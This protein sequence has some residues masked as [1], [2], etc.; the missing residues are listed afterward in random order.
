[1]ALTDSF[2]IRAK[3]IMGYARKEVDGLK[4]DVM[5]TEHVLLGIMR[6][7]TGVA[8]K[9]LKGIGLDW[10]KIRQEIIVRTVKSPFFALDGKSPF[11]EH[12]RA[13]L[14]HAIKAA[15]ASGGTLKTEH[16]LVGMLEVSECKAAEV[17]QGLGKNLADIRQ[18][19]LAM[20][21]AGGQAPS[22]PGAQMVSDFPAPAPAPAGPVTVGQRLTYTER[23]LKAL[24]YA[25]AEARRAGAPKVDA[26]HLVRGAERAASE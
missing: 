21:A 12:M 9:V 13:A 3:K 18:K 6:E 1:M 23:A 5:G 26:D 7:G 14:E 2:S 19:V 11:S 22:A 20:A 25:D 15:G 10:S 17:L 16:L 4:S 24:E 8:A